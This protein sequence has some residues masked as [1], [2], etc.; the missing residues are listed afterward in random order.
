MAREKGVWQGRREPGGLQ[1]GL[2]EVDE[3]R[4]VSFVVYSEIL[5]LL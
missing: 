3:V 5:A 2:Q 4:E 1:Q